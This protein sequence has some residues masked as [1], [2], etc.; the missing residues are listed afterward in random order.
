MRRIL[1]LSCLLL[2]LLLGS[3]LQA[4]NNFNSQPN[5]SESGVPP[6]SEEQEGVFIPNAF[7]PNDDGVNDIFYIPEANF[8]RF[9]IAVYDRWGNRVFYSDSPSFRW[10]GESAGRQVPQGVYV[11]VMTASTSRKS[12]IKRSGTITIVR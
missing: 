10:N 7:T 11:Y 8:I 6:K 9:E 1:S 2:L 12:D 3:A 4:Q 5:A